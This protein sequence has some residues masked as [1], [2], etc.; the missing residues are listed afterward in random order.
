MKSAKHVT[1]GAYTTNMAGEA[2]PPFYVLNSSAN[3]LWENF[4]LKVFEWLEG[5]H[6]GQ[7]DLAV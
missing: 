5:C 2:L 3:K 1:T 4:Q 7:R 6:Q